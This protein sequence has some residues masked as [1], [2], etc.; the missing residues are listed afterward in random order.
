MHSG[1]SRGQRETAK[2]QESTSPGHRGTA[3]THLCHPWGHSTA[4]PCPDL[5]WGLQDTVGCLGRSC[6][7][8]IPTSSSSLT[9]PSG[10]FGVGWIGYME[11]YNWNIYGKTKFRDLAVSGPTEGQ[12]WICWSKKGWTLRTPG[13][14]SPHIPVCVLLGRA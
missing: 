14:S 1:S 11:K 8:W 10:N 4:L 3:A 2:H 9:S 6:S 12:D 5:G 7:L 13:D